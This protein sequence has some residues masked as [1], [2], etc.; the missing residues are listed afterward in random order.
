MQMVTL[1]FIFLL[2]EC[3]HTVNTPHN[4]SEPA[5]LMDSIGIQYSLNPLA[6]AGSFP[7]IGIA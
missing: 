3:F 7:L 5:R 6:S 1:N 4:A 2:L